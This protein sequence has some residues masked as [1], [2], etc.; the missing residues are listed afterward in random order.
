MSLKRMKTRNGDIWP[1]EPLAIIHAVCHHRFGTMTGS[2]NTAALQPEYAQVV[3]GCLCLTTL[4]ASRRITQQ[5]D[6][7][8]APVSLTGPQFTLLAH[9][10]LKPRITVSAL[11]DRLAVD[12]TTLTRNLQL[13][14]KRLLVEVRTAEVDARQREVELLPAG[15]ELI[16]L[17]FPLWSLA[18][19]V[20]RQGIGTRDVD[21]ML[22]IAR[23]ITFGNQVKLR[24]GRRTS[25]ALPAEH[26]RMSEADLAYLKRHL[27]ICTTVRQLARH[28]TRI[29]DRSFKE[30]GI[31]IQQFHLLCTVA[32]QGA[33][34]QKEIVERLGLDQTTC[35][36][37]VQLAVRADLVETASD[38]R[39]NLTAKGHSALMAAMSLWSHAQDRLANELGE[40]KPSQF[41]E[42]MRSLI[43]ES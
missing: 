5:Y 34:R 20:T 35:S 42:L 23:D 28:V 11:A 37:N 25:K 24:S 33:M 1:F 2:R 43:T 7:M 8:L 15:D 31:T 38:Y 10:K 14:Q 41:L 29:Y 16:A 17:A 13:L 26:G 32:G 6:T 4:Q 21:Q 39:L 9:I 3:G 19:S 22:A 40:L 12:R 27:C 30:A 18:Q 36:R